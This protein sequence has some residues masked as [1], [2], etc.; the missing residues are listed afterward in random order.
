M[1]RKLFTFASALSLLLC[2]TTAVLWVRSYVLP[3]PTLSWGGRSATAHSITFFDGNGSF[4][5]IW[6]RR[7]VPAGASVHLIFDGDGF[8]R[9]GLHYHRMFMSLKE[10]FGLRPP[11]RLTVGVY[12]EFWF[13][14]LWPLVLTAILPSC[15][16]FR[17]LR[18][19]ARQRA[20]GMCRHCGYDLRASPDR[21]PECGT[22]VAKAGT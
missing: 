22:A 13:T 9:Y 16:T 12:S 17:S 2:V 14:L 20:Q 4:K 19:K 15:A 3:H 6:D 21:C 5:T 7:P 10:T 1:S 8:D 11:R 18:G